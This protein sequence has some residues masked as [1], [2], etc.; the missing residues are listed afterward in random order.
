M[1]GE[2]NISALIKEMNPILNEGEYVFCTVRDAG[3]IGHKEILG[4]FKEKEGTTLILERT[5]ADELHLN[6]DYVASWITLMVHSS[7]EAVGLTSAFS[8]ALA[9]NNISCNVVA[10]Y[11]HDHIFVGK[12][13]AKKAV[14]VLKK[15]SKNQFKAY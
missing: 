4:Q 11:Y 8:T 12:R 2:T 5:K 10:G 15:L 7:L 3:K 13:D 6:Y 14:E 9:Q 1:T